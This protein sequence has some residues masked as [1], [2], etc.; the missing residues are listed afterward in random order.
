MKLFISRVFSD[1]LH[2]ARSK[3]SL[4][5]INLIIYIFIFILYTY[6][7]G[8]FINGVLLV[9]KKCLGVVFSHKP[10]QN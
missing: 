7:F 8:R 5:F 1:Y 9:V 3:D 6:F 10:T 2:E 4:L